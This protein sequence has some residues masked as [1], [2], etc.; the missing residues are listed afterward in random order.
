MKI[1]IATSFTSRH[2]TVSHIKFRQWFSVLIINYLIVSMYLSNNCYLL[3]FIK[4]T[5]GCNSNRINL[6]ARLSLTDI[7]YC[8]K[9]GLKTDL[10]ESLCTIHWQNFLLQFKIRKLLQT[11]IRLNLR[12]TH[13]CK[14]KHNFSCCFFF[15]YYIFYD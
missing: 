15:L 9:V 2:H 5:I 11:S 7:S 6:L 10:W 8:L 4:L 14:C 1:K 3:F 13:C 12:Y